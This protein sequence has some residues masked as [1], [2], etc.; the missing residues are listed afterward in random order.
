VSANALVRKQQHANILPLLHS[1][2]YGSLCNLIFPLASYNLKEFYD[3]E[4]HPPLWHLAPEPRLRFMEKISRLIPALGTIHQGKIDSNSRW[5]GSHRDLKPAN[6]LVFGNSQRFMISDL[7]L[8]RYREVKSED[9]DYSGVDWGRG[10]SAYKAPECD[11]DGKKVGRGADIWS[12]GCILAEGITWCVCG[13][14]GIEQFTEKR[15]TKNLEN[16]T[17]DWFFSKYS[18][19]R[20]GKKVVT[21][22]KPE[23]R[24]WF[25]EIRRISKNSEDKP[26]PLICGA[27]KVVESMLKENPRGAKGRPTAEKIDCEF[28]AILKQEAD[29][30]GL[31]LHVDEPEYYTAHKRDPGRQPLPFSYSRSTSLMAPQLSQAKKRRRSEIESVP[32]TPIALSTQSS[33]MSNMSDMSTM[34]TMTVRPLKRKRDISAFVHLKRLDT[35]RIHPPQTTSPHTLTRTRCS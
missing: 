6:I 29:R 19:G 30:L 20:D 26:D 21:K 4:T 1:H 18:S 31:P 11:E 3:K 33:T 28:Y 22:L 10:T 12:M 7:G 8:M 34:S 23:V 16:Y 25:D 27:L 2:T 5:I 35:V 15:R 17:D 24:A 32:A 13:K 14:E 9:R